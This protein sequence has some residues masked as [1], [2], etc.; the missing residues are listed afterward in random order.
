MQTTELYEVEI[1][2]LGVTHVKKFFN[3]SKAVECAEEAV[4]DFGAE[5]SCVKNPNGTIYCEYEM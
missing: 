4:Y 5:Y 3:M 2:Y 1:D